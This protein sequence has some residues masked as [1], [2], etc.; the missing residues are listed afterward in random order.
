MTEAVSATRS[1][2][3]AVVDAPE[4]LA[5]IRTPGCAA[6][7]WRRPPPPGLLDWLARLPVERLPTMRTV[8]RPEQALSS[9]QSAC[10]AAGTPDG[11]ERARL[12]GDIAAL[13]DR[14]AAVMAAP[15]L[16]L[17]LDVITTD[18][19]RRFHIDA[20]TARLLCT[21]R[22]TGTQFGIAADGRD[23]D[24]IHTVPPGAVLILRGTRWSNDLCHPD[25]AGGLRHRSPPIAG[26]GE[27]RVL[28]VL[29]PV[30]DPDEAA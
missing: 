14:F 30:I 23:P 18:A 10:D 13:A 27:T 11:P 21:Y 19:C 29:D 15:L 9:L 1:E 8:L 28:L 6:V 12:I 26:S 24:T 22:G 25:P 4:G 16:L 7:L 5:Q 20:V 17:R 2:G 3:V